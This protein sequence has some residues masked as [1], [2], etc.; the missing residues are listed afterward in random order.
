VAEFFHK[1]NQ[2]RPTSSSVWF[3]DGVGRE[4]LIKGALTPE[5]AEVMAD[6]LNVNLEV[7]DEREI[8]ERYEQWKE[9]EL[10][11]GV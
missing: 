4:T 3:R 9:G 10:H 2:Q 1:V 7:P 6:N 8:E 11:E 5:E